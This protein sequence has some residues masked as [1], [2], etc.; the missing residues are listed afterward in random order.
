MN[1]K[2][3]SLSEIK[4][5]VNSENN[6]FIGCSLLNWE[7]ERKWM[8]WNEEE[9]RFESGDWIECEGSEELLISESGIILGF[10]GYYF[11]IF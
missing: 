2:E 10:K 7:E 8:L 1:N 6:G 4:E 9:N 11:E 5:M 3:L